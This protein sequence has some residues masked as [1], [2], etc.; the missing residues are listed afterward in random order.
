MKKI[1]FDYASTTPTD[2]RVIQSMNPYFFD[3]FANAS[4]P[5]TLGQESMIAIEESRDKV[6]SLIGAEASEIV[7]NSGATEANNHAISGIVY[8]AMDKGKN[9]I[10]LSS[11]EHH[12][13][14]EPVEQLLKNGFKVSFISVDEYGIVDPQDVKKALTKETMLIALMHANNEIGSIQRIKEVGMIAREMSIPFLVDAC[15]TVGHIPVNVDE[16]HCDLLSLSGHKFYGSKGVGALYIRKGLKVS[17]FLLGGDQEKSRRASTENVSGIVG[18]AC[19][20]T[21]CQ[22]NMKEEGVFQKHLRDRLF[23]EI[24]NKIEGVRINGHLMNRLPNNAHFSFKGLQGES[25]LMSLDMNG[26][27]ASMGSACTSGSIQS[28]HVLKA[29]GL[30]DDLAFGSLRITLGRWTKTE[31]I[32]YFLQELPR[33]VESLR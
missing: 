16:L 24:P 7:F 5:H 33:I 17:S 9:H 13:I 25:L 15:Q 29:I 21:L 22:D 28:S 12:S 23:K 14:L 30:K 32:D 27:C 6:A 26:V 20:V 31:D 4:S 18:L 2:P 8:H 19:A 1:Y 10:I 11:I 3:K